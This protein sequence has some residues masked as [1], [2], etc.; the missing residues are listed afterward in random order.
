[1]IT[2]LNIAV[3]PGIAGLP[4]AVVAALPELAV[5]VRND[6]V[7]LA[8]KELESTFLDYRE[9]VKLTK[10]QINS[11]SLKS[12]ER[13]FAT[14][15]LTGFLANAIEAGWGG[16]DMV[17]WLVGGRA[18]KQS[19]GSDAAQYATVPFRH[20]GVGAS[21]R[22][23]TPMGSREVGAGTMNRTQ[24]E[25]L[26]KRIHGAAKKL[27]ASTSAPKGGTAWGDRLSSATTAAL[28]ARKIKAVHS[29]DPYAGMARME[30]AYRSATQN[31]YQTFRRV[32]T[33]VSGKWIHPGIDAH[34]F[35]GKALD[36]MPGHADLI[37]GG[38]IRGLMRGPA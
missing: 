9:N 3:P 12:G 7:T 23:G 26:G 38:M 36:R 27:G 34:D 35:F 13:T 6:I 16:G 11:K 32:S 19:K 28:G 1:M 14:I 15:T 24:A 10:F 29:H 30:K 31:T 21:R 22:G 33:N 18:G 17:G 37:V 5:A 8:G 2:V 4:E 25:L 20:K